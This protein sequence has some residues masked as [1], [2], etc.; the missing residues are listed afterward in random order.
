M[1]ADRFTTRTREALEAAITLARARRNPEAGPAHLL[2]A[3]LDQADGFSVPVLRRVGVEPGTVRAANAAALDA[4]PTLS[5]PEASAPGL[6][7]ELAQVLRAAEQ[8]MRDLTDEYVSVEHLLLALAAHGSKAGAALRDAGAR[9]EALLEAVTAIRGSHRVTDPDPEGKYEALKTYG[10]DLTE[11]AEEGRLDP[12][13]GRDDEIRRVIQVLS[14]R[15]KNN[16][17]L[18]GEPGVGKTAIAEGLAQRIIAG[19]VP[20]GLKGKRV[21]TL[22]M[23]AL[24]AGAKYRGEFEERLKAVLKEVSD[25]E[26]QIILFLDELHTI[27][28]AGGA[29]GAVDAANLLKPML[30]RG[31][32]RA[33]GATTLKEYRQ[34]EKDAALERRFQ[35]VVVDE[36][37]VEDTI[38]ILRGLR[39]RYETHHDVTIQDAAL[40]AAATLSHRYIADRFL[41]DKAIDLVDEA[42]A[43]LQVENDSQPTEIDEVQRRILQLQIEQ[44]SLQQ[45]TDAA[46][47]GRL[48]TLER[49]L[50]ELEEQYDQMV[51]EWHQE[52]EALQGTADVRTRLDAARRELERAEREFDLEVAAELRHGEIPELE[53]SSRGRG[54]RGRRRPPETRFLKDTS[55]RRTSRRRRPLDRHPRSPACSRARSRSSC[56]WRTACTSASWARTRRSRPC[57]RAAPLAR[58]PAGP[59]PAHRLVPLP[60]PDRRRQ[61]RARP[62]AAEFMFDSAGRDGPHRHVEYMEKHSVARLVGAPP[63]TSGYDEGGQLTEAVR[64]RR[65]RRACSTRSRRPTP[66]CS[67]RCCQV[68]DDGADRRPGPHGRLQ[69]RRAGHDSNTSDGEATFRPEFI[70]RLDD[71]VALPRARSRAHRGDRR[72]AGRAARR[73]GARA[74]DR[75]RADPGRPRAA[76]DPGLRPRV[77][78]SAA[79]ARHPEA[80]GRPARA[81]DP[82]GRVHPGRHRQRRRRGRRCRAHASRPG[83]RG[84]VSAPGPP[85]RWW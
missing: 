61:D 35:P 29:E 44:T 10:I 7:S 52:K 69:E 40:I 85:A 68:M 1:N 57:P 31:E 49:E 5:T 72:E 66:T 63:A 39:E 46:S 24:V 54:H 26:G 16:P 47:K 8:E 55:T 48:D 58:R 60:R 42:A 36:P 80:A 30:A 6:S 77:R 18:I 62:R 4:L 19:D 81:G 11:R 75:G 15:T 34:I 82:A 37:S 33:V 32:L 78:R 71:I 76:R 12:V 17:V 51:A 14:R 28:G 83:D 27:V 73:A 74:R 64:R 41:P 21:I 65:T 43:G 2:A 59:R 38:A 56:T 25:A 13:I 9:R 3:L 45:E 50:A 70:N 84:G 23:G 22:D 67:T 20:D 53:R 79:Q